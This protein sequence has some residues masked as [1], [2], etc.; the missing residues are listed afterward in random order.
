MRPWI[1][2][3]AVAGCSK[4]DG[5]LVY[6][7]DNTYSYAG[8]LDIAAVEVR[9]GAEVSVDWSGLTTDIRGRPLDPTTVEQA[10]F[11][12]LL[13]PLD[14]VLDLIAA[15]EIGQ[16]DS[17][18]IYL[19]QNDGGSTADLSTFEST[20]P[21]DLAVMTEDP[22]VTWLLSVMNVPDGRN[23][24][25]SSV[26]LVPK[27]AATNQ[28][29]A[30]TASTASLTV[31]VHLDGAPLTTAAGRGP[32]ALD[33]SGATVDVFGHPFDPLIGDELV[34]AH[35]ATE[36]PAEVEAAFL[37]LDTAADRLYRLDAFGVTAV[38]DLAAAT[39]GSG[40]AFDGFTADGTWL[41][42]ISCTTCTT[43][44]PLLLTVVEVE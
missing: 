7:D 17:P 26:V 39:D 25:L 38:D 36:D 40:A 34:L 12:S 44:V 27:V 10:S 14:E 41:A 32:Y 6:G 13:G 33:W 28:A 1:A 5:A 30:L 21:I 35:F 22:N 11:L 42:G 24:I 18:L 29:A 15:N 43:P 20:A 4:A 31:D 16:D 3:A 9:A 2:L 23:D 8:V 37:Q 19:H